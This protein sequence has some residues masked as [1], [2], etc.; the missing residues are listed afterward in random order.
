MIARQQPA[1]PLQDAVL[2]VVGVEVGLLR[3]G[4]QLLAVADDADLDFAA[5]AVRLH[6]HAEHVDA[7][8][9][10]RLLRAVGRAVADRDDPLEAGGDDVEEVGLDADRQRARVELPPAPRVHDPEA[11]AVLDVLLVDRLV[12]DFDHQAVRV[13]RIADVFGVREAFRALAPD[14]DDRE[15]FARHASA[16]T[17][18]LVVARR[19]RGRFALV[20]AHQRDELL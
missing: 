5:E 6:V 14:G 9:G 1:D 12:V 13:E 17:A 7:L 19:A 16:V 11:G 2:D 15:A 10:Q 18:L 3:D 4:R 8:D 20:D